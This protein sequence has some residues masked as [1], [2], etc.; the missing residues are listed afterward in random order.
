MTGHFFLLLSNLFCINVKFQLE[1]RVPSARIHDGYRGLTSV[2][3]FQVIFHIRTGP[4]GT[5]DIITHNRVHVSLRS[6]ERS[7]VQYLDR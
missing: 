2:D 4:E 7:S 1:L 6:T 3:L 5:V